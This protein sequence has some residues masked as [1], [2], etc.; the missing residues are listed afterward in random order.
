MRRLLLLAAAGLLLAG[1]SGDD[2][3]LA[4]Q[5]GVV[6]LKVTGTKPI[7]ADAPV[8]LSPDGTHLLRMAGG[9]CVS[10]LD[11]TGEHC[12][13]DADA[14]QARWSPD[15]TEIVL[16]GDFF[17]FLRE[18]DI[19]VLDVATGAL[20]D[21]TD[22]GIDDHTK[23][24]PA[25]PD[26][27]A[28]I[29]VLPSWS[30]DGGTIRFARGRADTTDL[31]SVPARGGTPDKLG[32]IDCG[33][34]GLGALAWSDDRVAWACGV[35]RTTVTLAG[36]DG[37]G[38]RQVLDGDDWNGL[39][40]SPDGRWLLADSTDQYQGYA[41][42]TGGVARAVPANGG[43]PVRVADGKVAFPA[44]APTGHALAYVEPPGSIRVVPEPGGTPVTLH[45]AG[46]VS[47][48][49]TSSL[50]WARGTLLATLDG[51]PTLLTLTG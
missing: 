50:S 43:A 10:A 39:S 19:Q 11:G 34:A 45:T 6:A 18:P 15:G 9:L 44:W 28:N 1:C 23:V 2:E 27:R 49:D 37:A 22:D 47:A 29:D 31:M 4:P 21:L 13:A 42:D 7:D 38:A 17:Q 41:T 36:H 30:S 25:G 26:P 46:T 24:D 32:T 33:V 8:R 5:A 35:D 3:P 12:V 48:A 20:R 40:F 16:T 14:R 51:T